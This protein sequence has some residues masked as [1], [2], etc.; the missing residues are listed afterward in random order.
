MRTL[1]VLSFLLISLSLQAVTPEVGKDKL[2]RLVKLPSVYFQPDWTFDPERGFT[3]GSRE[4]NTAD[5]IDALLKEIKGD[6]SDAERYAQLGRLYSESNDLLN[7]QS[8]WTKATELYRKRVELQPDDGR[9]LLEFGKALNNA[10]RQNEAE[11]ILRRATQ[12][13]PKDWKTW[14]TLGRFLDAQARS[15]MSAANIRKKTALDAFK[16]SFARV[17]QSQTLLEEARSCFEKA[18]AVAPEDG[19]VYFRRAMHHSL[20]SYLLA[21]I[22]R[23]AGV[24]AENPDLMAKCFTSETLVDLQKARDLSPN[25]HKRILSTV[26]FE[27]Y[28]VKNGKL[29]WKEGILWDS[30]PDKSQDSIRDAVTRLENLSQAADASLAAGAAEALGILQGSILR[31]YRCSIPNLRR[32]TALDPNRGQAWESLSAVLAKSQNFTDLLSTCE[33]RLKHD[34]SGH[35]RLLMS[36]ACE[37]VKLWEDAEEHA[38]AAVKENPN[39]FAA[40]LSVAALRLRRMQDATASGEVNG[41]LGRA[42]NLLNS[43]PDNQKTGQQLID[44]AVTRSIYFALNDDVQSARKWVNVIQ[45]RD[46]DNDLAQ[47]IL[48]AMQY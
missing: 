18:V 34:D 39:D 40:N 4:E 47:E 9:L 10:G 17:H 5:K 29:N 1:V 26:L 11:S 41:W 35:A 7:T 31:E 30:L 2:R 33:E 45:E 44:L 12:I 21:Q 42:E 28:T 25:D 16:P 36:K 23:A 38:L 14:V 6:V 24:Q 19:E 37:K 22:D 15:Q 13:A 20:E 48:S 3:I 8:S 46:K 43:L 27:I 32:A